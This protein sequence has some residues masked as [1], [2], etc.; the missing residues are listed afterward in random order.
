MF[1]GR[2]E[3]YGEWFPVTVGAK[4]GNLAWQIQLGQSYIFGF[5]KAYWILTL[6]FIFSV[7]YLFFK[8]KENENVY[9]LMWISLIV[10]SGYLLFNLLVGGDWMLGWRFITPVLVFFALVIGLSF[11]IFNN[12]FGY[13]FLIIILLANIFSS[14]ELHSASLNQAMS[15]RGDILMGQYIYSL[16]LPKDTK[17]AVIDAGAIPYYAKLSTIDMI[18]LNDNHISKLEGGFLQKY[19]NDYVLSHKPKIIQFHTKYI[20]NKGDVAPTEAFR[21][22]LVLFYTNEFQQWYERDKNSP[23]PHLF[24]RREKPIEKTFLDTYYDADL[25]LVSKSDSKII[26]DVVKKGDGTW[27]G[28]E[29]DHMET[30]VVYLRTQAVKNDGRI[31]YESLTSIPHKMNKDDTARVEVA[32]PKIED[33]FKWVIC[34]TLLGV[35]DFYLC[36]QDGG[37]Q[38][39]E[40]PLHE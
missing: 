11:S 30:G 12:K 6:A 28:Q 15:D 7:G 40:R 20:N 24:T 25:N 8:R 36:S 5:L 27:L 17:I 23:I 19:D 3:I 2:H 37:I 35:K 39:L 22:A 26:I 18:G 9:L 33:N 16:K 29:S 1:L 4:T 21:G 13:L 14:K 38:I 32:L 10:V 34:P 31:I